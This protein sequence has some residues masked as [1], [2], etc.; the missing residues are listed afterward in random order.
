[1]KRPVNAGDLVDVVGRRDVCF[2][3]DGARAQAVRD[4]GCDW[5][6]CR[7]HGTL[8]DSLVYCRARWVDDHSGLIVNLL[9]LDK[10]WG[11]DAAGEGNFGAGRGNLNSEML[12]HLC[13]DVAL[14][15]LLVLLI[16]NDVGL[17]TR[18]A[19]AN[20]PN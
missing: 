19:V 1:M 18:G 4:A 8:L 14:E 12:C 11:D 17:G 16:G 13:S 15:D 5:D 2:H 7:A 20:I 10:K 3:Q 9:V 6:G